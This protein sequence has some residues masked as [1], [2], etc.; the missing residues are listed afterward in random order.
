MSWE[1]REEIRGKAFEDEK[2]RLRE[3]VAQRERERA[4]Q[5]ERERL[6]IAEI[7]AEIK[8]QVTHSLVLR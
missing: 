7:E 8:T 2:R 6:R 5:A 1:K 3:E 4:E